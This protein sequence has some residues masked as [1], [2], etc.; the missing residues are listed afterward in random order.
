MK[1]R[2]FLMSTLPAAI[3]PAVVNG[4]SIRTIGQSAF[5][6]SMM[7]FS[8][9]TDRVLVIIQLNGGNDGL[10]TVIPRDSYAAY[11]NA[12]KNI[13]IPENK[14]LTLNGNAKTGLHPS[15]KGMQALYNEG[16]MSIIQS[17]G[18]PEPNFSHFRASDIWMSGSDSNQNI[19]SGWVG[20]YLK[21]QYANFPIG[22]WFAYITYFTGTRC[23][24]G[25]EYYEF[26]TIL[27][28]YKWSSGTSAPHAFRKRIVIYQVGCTTDPAIYHG[29]K[30]S[31]GP[32]CATGYI[33]GQ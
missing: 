18:Y 5:L 28:P 29:Y 19:N 7:N 17:V 2:D 4:H 15:M 30:K 13:A 14:I 8:T 12:R 25:D 11:S 32:G 16:K 1:R 26:Y 3:L 20:R 24:Y 10:N 6:D 21:D 33:S 23:Q 27:Q 22:Y 9:E 31:G